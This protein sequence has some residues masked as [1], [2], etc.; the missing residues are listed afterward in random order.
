MPH[1][2]KRSRRLSRSA[3]VA[4]LLVI[5]VGL[6]TCVTPTPYQPAVERYG[7]SEQQI[8]TG[9]FKVSFSGNSLTDRETVENYLLYRA[10]EVTLNAGNDYFVVADRDT[11]E[12]TTYRASPRYYPYSYFHYSLFYHRYPF[13][14]YGPYG[15]YGRYG[16]GGFGLGYDYYSRPITRYTATA[17]IVA[18]Q[19]DKPDNNAS[20]YNARE[21]I[22]NLGP[23]IVRPEDLAG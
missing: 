3:W 22:S 2:Q 6:G 8:E 9:R 21:V 15:R 11:S 14:G 1:L 12:R 7:Y 18:Y 5:G 17:D 4:S 13:Y 16:G 23:N 19:G 10:A 20:A